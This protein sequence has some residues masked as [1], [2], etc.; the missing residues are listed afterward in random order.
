[1]TLRMKKE[2]PCWGWP[3]KITAGTPMGFTKGMIVL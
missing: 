1:M 2:R 3:E